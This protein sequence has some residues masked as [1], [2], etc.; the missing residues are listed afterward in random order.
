MLTKWKVFHACVS[1]HNASEDEWLKYMQFFSFCFLPFH[2]TLYTWKQPKTEF[3]VGVQIFFPFSFSSFSF[4][5]S[6]FQLFFVKRSDVDALVNIPVFFMGPMEWRRMNRKYRPSH[7]QYKIISEKCAQ[8]AYCTLNIAFCFALIYSP[9]FYIAMNMFDLRLD[10]KKNENKMWKRAK[11][12]A[13][14]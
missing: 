4:V 3:N 13:D 9:W 6:I 10:L 5:F 11:W 7:E 12:I 1:H 8:N 2:R 14:K